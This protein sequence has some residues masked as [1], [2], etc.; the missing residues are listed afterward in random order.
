[1][2]QSG[3]TPAPQVLGEALL[4]AIRLVVRDEIR[5]ALRPQ[6][7]SST[8][9]AGIGEAFLTIK[10]AADLSRIAPSTIRLYIRQRRL[11]AQKVGRRVIIKRV[12]LENFLTAN[13]IEI[14]HE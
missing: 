1:M 10:E 7:Q 13:P 3:Q 14:L 9:H 2:N 5:A 11:R 4:E 6:R 8:Y 12:D